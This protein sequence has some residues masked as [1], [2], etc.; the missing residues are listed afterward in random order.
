MVPLYT[1]KS[2]SEAMIIS[3]LLK[4][5]DVR[6]LIQGGEFSSLYPAAVTTSLNEQVLLVDEA[7]I[8]LARELLGSFLDDEAG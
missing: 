6:F 4:A 1:P 7:D 2:E 3:S 8:A 5:Y